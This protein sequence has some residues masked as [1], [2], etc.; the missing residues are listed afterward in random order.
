MEPVKSVD[1]EMIIKAKALITE[2]IQEEEERFINRK[3]IDEDDIKLLKKLLNAPTVE[4]FLK[5][6]WGKKD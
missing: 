1:E 5:L 2:R 3:P 4:I 6:I